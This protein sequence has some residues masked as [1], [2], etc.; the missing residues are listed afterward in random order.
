MC[1][2]QFW[3]NAHQKLSDSMNYLVWILTNKTDK[4]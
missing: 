3:K 4:E 1:I 2:V